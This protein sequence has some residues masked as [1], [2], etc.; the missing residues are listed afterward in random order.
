M[1]IK[2]GLKMCQFFGKAFTRMQQA[3]FNKR[4]LLVVFCSR[5][6]HDKRVDS[7]KL[8]LHVSILW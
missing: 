6:R 5:H 7:R 2:V 4:K 1:I 3:S 8:T